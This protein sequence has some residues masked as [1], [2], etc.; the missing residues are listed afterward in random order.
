MRPLAKIQ[1]G[2]TQVFKM[3]PG[4]WF[5]L[6]SWA[7]VANTLKLEDVEEGP[8]LNVRPASNL[9]QNWVSIKYFEKTYLSV[10]IIT[11]IFILL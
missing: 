4:L 5:L 9:N 6:I 7:A 3:A 10:I 1:F 11:L 8:C 2:R